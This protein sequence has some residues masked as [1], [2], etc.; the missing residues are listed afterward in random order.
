MNG[1]GCR[2]WIVAAALLVLAAG[3]AAAQDRRPAR[4][5]SEVPYTQQRLRKQFQALVRKMVEV[6]DLV[7]EREPAT[8]RAIRAAVNQAQRALIDENMAKVVEHFNR[9]L[10]AL[11]ESTQ[12]DVVEELRK[13]LRTLEQG[14]LSADAEK[15]RQW[16]EYLQRI[17]ELTRNR[18]Y[19]FWSGC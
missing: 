6:A 4:A 13:V 11:A 12:A 10:M 1:H 16:R 19:R 2:G 15:I 17:Q 18:C 5:G 7:A 9:G 8:A 14:D 3:A